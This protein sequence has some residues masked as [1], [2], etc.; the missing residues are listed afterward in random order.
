M[1]S[2]TIKNKKKENDRTKIKD[3]VWEIIDSDE[4]EEKE[5]IR[6]RKRNHQHEN[7]KRIEP[8]AK[9]LKQN[10]EKEIKEKITEKKKGVKKIKHKIELNLLESDS[11]DS[12]KEYDYLD[13]SINYMLG[14]K[15]KQKKQ[16]KQEKKKTQREKKQWVE[17]YRDNNTQKLISTKF[18]KEVEEWMDKATEKK[19][20]LN[21][22]KNNKFN[23][24]IEDLKDQVENPYYPKMM[25]LTGPPGCCKKSLIED[26]A[27]EKQIKLEYFNETH[28]TSFR[29]KQ[30]AMQSLNF[31]EKANFNHYKSEMEYI[32]E[33]LTDYRIDESQRR[34]K[35]FQQLP[36]VSQKNI[37]KMYALIE[38]YT[39]YTKATQF[40]SQKMGYKKYMMPTRHHTPIIIIHT[41][42]QAASTYA[43]IYKYFPLG[44]IKGNF[45]NYVELKQITE[46]RIKGVLKHI[47]KNEHNYVPE[48]TLEQLAINAKGDLRQAINQLEFY[49]SGTKAVAPMKANEN[50]TDFYRS[51]FHTTNKLIYAKRD[52]DTNQLDYQINKIPDE[53]HTTPAKLIPYIHHNLISHI[54]DP[55]AYE[56][57]MSYFSDS[58]VFLQQL[59]PSFVGHR[60]Y[61]PLYAYALAARSIAVHLPQ[62]ARQKPK[63]GAVVSPKWSTI[64]YHRLEKQL[65]A[66]EFYEKEQYL[67]QQHH[68]QQLQQIKPQDLDELMVLHQKQQALTPH[69]F[70]DK[71]TIVNTIQ[72]ML[73]DTKK[74][75]SFITTNYKPHLGQIER[76]SWFSTSSKT[77]ITHLSNL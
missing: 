55:K 51:I 54:K 12:E 42:E 49:C 13:N 2:S 25:L 9:K 69:R 75:N 7:W 40:K 66:L 14:I 36:Q 58:D 72:P 41:F 29:T 16:K 47:A 68:L 20:L 65:Q 8:K 18:R 56:K 62:E 22:I 31:K 48:D 60:N 52:P 74:V 43:S 59:Q 21:T 5:N 44:M 30:Y 26:L 76:A 71:H 4:E 23:R 17:K 63:F 6:K 35:V 53:I 33:F 45:V 46:H 64:K 24:Q 67:Q 1:Q 28:Y 70:L 57:I 10:R 37:E 27:K 3:I 73:M 39:G 19:I 61:N 38:K 77:S 15:T 50:A 32:K 11:T 34:I